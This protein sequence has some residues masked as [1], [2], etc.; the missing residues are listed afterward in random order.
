MK[1][2]NT[3]IRK[4]TK[5]GRYMK[6]NIRCRDGF[7]MSVIAG[8]GCYC[9]PRPSLCYSREIDILERYSHPCGKCNPD[10]W[11]EDANCAYRGPYTHVEVGFPSLTPEPWSDWESYCETPGEPS[12]SVYAYVPVEL[13]KRLII[14]HG[15]E[16]IHQDGPR[17]HRRQT[18]I[19]LKFADGEVQEL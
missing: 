4:G 6:N 16:K 14:K 7:T 3:I 19:R 18:R 8:W 15:G 13:V 1:R 10:G 9:T 17:K 5:K 12:D 2:I 11:M